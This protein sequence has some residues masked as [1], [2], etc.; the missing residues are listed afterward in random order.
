MSECRASAQKQV[1]GADRSPVLRWAYHLRWGL[2][3]ARLPG[4]RHLK[5]RLCRGPGVSPHVISHVAGLNE[6]SPLSFLLVD[7]NSLD[8]KKKSLKY[9]CHTCTQMMPDVPSRTG[10]DVGGQRKNKQLGLGWNPKGHTHEGLCLLPA[11]IMPVSGLAAPSWA[12]LPFRK[13]LLIMQNLV[14][15]NSLTFLSPL[16]L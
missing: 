11:A 13:C 3:A 9:K 5:P 15:L 4:G 1:A 14:P 16:G 6:H 12:A 8:G 7:N 2:C 10:C